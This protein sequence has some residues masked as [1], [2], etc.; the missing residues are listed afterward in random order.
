MTFRTREGVPATKEKVVTKM[1][2]CMVCR[3]LATEEQVRK[4]NEIMIKIG[5]KTKDAREEGM[6][7][8]AKGI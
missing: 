1:R 5:S 3:I 6:C 7:L 8:V 2:A 4:E